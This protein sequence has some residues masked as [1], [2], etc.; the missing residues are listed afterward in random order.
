MPPDLHKLIQMLQA[1]RQGTRDSTVVLGV[2]AQLRQQARRSL[3]AH[4]P[5]R[6]TMD[7]EDLVMDTVLD[8]IHAVDD[9]RGRTWGEFFAFAAAVQQRRAQN[10]GRR[11]RVRRD[12]LRASVDPNREE[13]PGSEPSP[14]FDLG[15]QEDRDRLLRLIDE[16]PADYRQALRL[17]LAGMD[18]ATIATTLGLREDAARQRIARA[19]AMLKAKW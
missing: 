16:L 9:F 4:A 13:L 5:M 19:L 3:P 14:S 12:E 15:R 6:R 17:R 7:S 11:A 8:L 1:V 18:N 2:M 10:H